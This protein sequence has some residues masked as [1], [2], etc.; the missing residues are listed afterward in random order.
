M[1]LKGENEG[2]KQDDLGYVVGRRQDMSGCCKPGMS[3]LL[4]CSE[5]V[6]SGRTKAISSV[7][8]PFSSS[9]GLVQRLV[10]VDRL[11]GNMLEASDNSWRE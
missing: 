6:L 2:L 8:C 7:Q 10:A 4:K 3:L 11:W 5:T 9:S 1:P